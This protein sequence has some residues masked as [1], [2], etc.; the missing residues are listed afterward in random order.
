MHNIIKLTLIA[1]LLFTS[2][3]LGHDSMILPVSRNGGVPQDNTGPCDS[4]TKETPI[5]I[6][7]GKQIQVEWGNAHETGTY[8]ITIAPAAQDTSVSAFKSLAAVAAT[9]Q[10]PQSTYVTIPS[11]LGLGLFTLRWSWVFGGGLYANCVD[12]RVTGVPP[13]QASGTGGGTSPIDSQPLASYQYVLVNNK[14]SVGVYDSHTGSV[15]CVK[16]YKVKD[17]ECVKSSSMT[18]G[19][20]AALAFFFIFLI[21]GSVCG[22]IY[23][24]KVKR[25]IMYATWKAKIFKSAT[26]ARGGPARSRV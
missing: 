14:K 16:G 19:G 22:A 1:V 6:Q 20:Q 7:S 15:T 21:V 8:D 13:S 17:N 24:V 3:C 12:L 10:Q 25:P 2:V 9:K 23:Y 5:D 11:D 4:T 26:E 18:P